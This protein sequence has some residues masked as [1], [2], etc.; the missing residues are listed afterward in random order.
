MWSW[1]LP[2]RPAAPERPAAVR[3]DHHKVGEREGRRGRQRLSDRLAVT[4]AIRQVFI[5]L[6]D[7]FPS[8]W[9]DGRR[10]ERTLPASTRPEPVL[11][12]RAANSTRR[13]RRPVSRPRRR[14][15]RHVRGRPERRARPARG[16]AGSR[17]RT[18]GD[19]WRRGRGEASRSPRVRLGAARCLVRRSCD[20]RRRLGSGRARDE[21]PGGPPLL[22]PRCGLRFDLHPQRPAH[23]PDRR[24]PVRRRC[25]TTGRDCH[26][27]R[28]GER[29]SAAPR[30]QQR[31]R[32]RRAAVGSN[33]NFAGQAP[34]LGA[35]LPE[36][37]PRLG[38]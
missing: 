18:G 14:L 4:A 25:D 36:Q 2:T 29:R 26:A 20:P 37:G 13:A 10:V 38:D 30:R 34:D 6:G 24:Q 1:C 22:R 21:Q 8:I 33:N 28:P 15:C 31:G 17:R 9:A 35:P 19:R 27:R 7:T 11:P 32:Y 23:G 3:G 5:A 12:S 16:L